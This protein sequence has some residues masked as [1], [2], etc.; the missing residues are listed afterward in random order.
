M[1]EN[2]QVV[3]KTLKNMDMED[4]FGQMIE[5]IKENGKMVNNMVKEYI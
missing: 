3:I 2:I 5:N 4:L 1:E